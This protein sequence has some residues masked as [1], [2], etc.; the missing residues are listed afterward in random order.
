MKVIGIEEHLVT[1]DV[2]GAWSAASLV[3]DDTRLMHREEID[4]RLTDLGGER[5]RLMDETGVDVQVLSLTSPGLH[6]LAG[7]ESV[8]VARRTNDLIAATV[9]ARPDRFQGFATLPTPSPQ[10]AARELERAVRDLGLKGAMVFGRTREKNLDH[11]DFQPIL[12]RAAALRVPLFIHPQIPQRPVRAAYYSGLGEAV[13]LAFAAFG[14]GWHYETGI[15]FLR[16]VLSGTF[17]RIP[18]LQV[19]LGHWGEVVVF[20]AERIEALCRMARLRLPLEGYLRR[21][22]HLTCSGMYSPTYLARALEI[23][24]ADR[25]LFSTDYPYQYRPGGEARRFLEEARLEPGDREKLAH[26]NWE[27][28]TRQAS[29]R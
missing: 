9:A 25:L 17:D 5:L 6:N 14:L 1:V 29:P 2:Q 20:Y 10:D 22:V 28:L 19:I 3:D 4:R 8:A 27:R 11:P 16:L 21:N 24:G 15:Q 13:D 26:A 7:A 23:V 18:D 12:E